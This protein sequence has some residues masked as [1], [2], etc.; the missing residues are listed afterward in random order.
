MFLDSHV[1]SYLQI[2]V[3]LGDVKRQEAPGPRLL[4]AVQLVRWVAELGWFLF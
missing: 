3:V 1:S 2:H 4:I